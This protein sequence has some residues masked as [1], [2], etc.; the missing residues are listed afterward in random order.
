MDNDSRTANLMRLIDNYAAAWARTEI[1]Y[2]R[3]ALPS[4]TK[5]LNDAQEQHKRQVQDE[6]S[7]LL[8]DALDNVRP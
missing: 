2:A 3:D 8:D 6:I 5:R 4:Q 7:R 1:A